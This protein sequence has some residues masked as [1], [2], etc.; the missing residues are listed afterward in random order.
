MKDNAKQR[1]KTECS[2]NYFI[3]I[4]AA[5]VIKHHDKSNL[6]EKGVSWI[7]RNWIPIP[8]SFYHCGEVNSGT[9]NI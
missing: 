3:L 2:E 4:S 5:T 7:T 9:S 6:G 8:N 1:F